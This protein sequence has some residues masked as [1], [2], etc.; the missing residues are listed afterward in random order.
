MLAASVE[1]TELAR[2]NLMSAWR[3]RGDACMALFQAYSM[4]RAWSS[5]G[6]ELKKSK[7]DAGSSPGS[8]GC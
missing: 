5:A 1:A 4:M 3:C 2:R 8:V 7:T 6:R